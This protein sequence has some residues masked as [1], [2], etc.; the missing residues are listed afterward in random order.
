MNSLIRAFLWFLFP[1]PKKKIPKTKPDPLGPPCE[2]ILISYI[3]W[4][5]PFIGEI[6]SRGGSTWSDYWNQLLGKILSYPM[7]AKDPTDPIIY[8]TAKAHSR[9]RLLI[10]GLMGAS[11]KSIS[12]P[13]IDLSGD[14]ILK[15]KLR[16]FRGKDG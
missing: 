2:I 1:K 8:R 9:K 16:K 13:N 5:I 12:V 14:T 3:M 7:H 15:K 6:L 10:L 4:S 11:T